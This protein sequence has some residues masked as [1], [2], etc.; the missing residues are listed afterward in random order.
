LKKAVDTGVID[1]W[2]GYTRDT[3]PIS[4]PTKINELDEILNKD[5]YTSL[6]WSLALP[7]TDDNWTTFVIPN[8]DKFLTAVENLLNQLPT[9]LNMNTKKELA[10]KIYYR[11]V[12]DKV[13]EKITMALS[14]VSTMV[15]MQAENKLLLLE[16]AN[17]SIGQRI[18]SDLIY[19][20]ARLY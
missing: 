15:A 7:W 5:T 8:M 16:A 4:L 11:F 20:D 19:F 14:Y 12:E 2:A 17:E 3:A 1:D 9:T 10:T 6:T 18:G 13:V